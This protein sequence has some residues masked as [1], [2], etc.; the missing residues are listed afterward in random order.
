MKVGI[1][2]KHLNTLGGGEKVATV[3]AEALSKKGYDVDLI[4]QMV[5]DK[6]NI[7][8][9]MGVNL[10]RVKIVT[11]YE[12]LYKKLE[13]RTEKYDIF[14]NS[15]YLDHQP[16]L[17]K[18]SIYYVHFPTPIRRN[19]LGF[20][21]YEKVLP[22]LRQFLIIP[23]V[24][25]GLESIED[26]IVRGG[27][28]LKKENT[29]VLSN[30]P[31]KF[32]IK[33]RFYYVSM[34]SKSTK[35]LRFSSPNSKLNFIDE[36]VDH[37]NN[38]IT[39]S[40]EVNNPKNENVVLNIDARANLDRD[41]IALVSMTVMN[42]RYFL[43]NFMKKYLPTYEMALYGS[44][45]YRP[46]SGLDSY[47]L[48]LVNSKFTG[49]WVKKYW[50]K[51]YKILYPPVDTHS[52]KPGNKRNII[53]NVGRFF[54]GG[55][56]KRQDILAKAFKELIDSG[57]LDISWE[58]HLVGGVSFGSENTE[59][60]NKIKSVAR[61]YPV[62]LHF[63]ASFDDL[64]DLYSKAKIYWHATGYEINERFEPI[65]LEHFGITPVEAMAAGCVPL[66]YAGGGVKESVDKQSGYLW[67]TTKQLKELTARL[68]ENSKILK[69]LSR[70]A[71][72]RAKR[73]SKD[74]FKE[75]LIEY[76]KLL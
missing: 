23:Q 27:K 63:N 35:L 71:Q 21:K 18:K 44:S 38:V 53:L 34:R 47:N 66:V 42:Y 22:C 61:D 56:S 26:V 52:F 8:K 5:V 28:W 32:K 48:F 6:Q 11:W 30:P 12:R 69:S 76:T 39:Y 9:R 3:M 33:F 65:K 1:Y 49:K 68:S 67:R 57:G 60:M 15:S 59:F 41:P 58:L 43:W 62:V 20:I 16:S 37:H 64:K 4:S 13:P 2:A 19:F 50:D 36:Y 17:A 54:V 46:A 31:E 14:I 55:H 45:S 29:I 70:G 7:E 25:R 72:K 24:S 73:F 40:Y 74:R 75:E 10:R 51:E